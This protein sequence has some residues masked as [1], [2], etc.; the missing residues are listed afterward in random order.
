MIG[1][2]MHQSRM[3]WMQILLWDFLI[4]ISILA[5]VAW[6]LDDRYARP[7]LQYLVDFPYLGKLIY[8]SP[9]FGWYAQWHYTVFLAP[10]LLI[11]I[12]VSFR[13]ARIPG[14]G[15]A[16]F[17]WW[18]SLLQLRVRKEKFEDIFPPQ[19]DRK[20]PEVAQLLADLASR[21]PLSRVVGYYKR[22][23]SD[24]E[25]DRRAGRQPEKPGEYFPIVISESMRYRHIQVLG[26]T[27]SGKSA[28]IIAPMLI[29]D[30]STARI[31]TVTINPKADLYLLKV[32]AHGVMKRKRANPADRM[33]TAVISFSRTDS[34]AYDPLLYGDADTLTKKIIG[35][36][37]ISHPFYRSFQET[38]LMSF[39]RVIKT[40]PLLVDRIMLRHLFRFLTRPKEVEEALMSLCASEHNIQRLRVLATA[41]PEFLAGVASHL[42]LLVEDESLA[43]IFDNPTGPQLN[44]REVIRRGGNIFLDLDL[45]TKGPQ[46]RALGRMIMME[47]QLLAGSRQAGFESKTTG[48]QVYLD[49]FASF[50]YNGFIDLIDKCRSARVGLL[51][52]HQSLGNLQRDNLTKS[53]KDEVVDN[54][55]CKFFL[56]LKDQTAEWASRQMGTR[57][58]LKKT[59]TIGHATEQTDTRGRQ[60]H[61]LA[62]REE[63]EPYVQ[64]SDLHVE[65]GHGY[66]NVVG[67]D[68]RMIRCPI[69]VGYIDEND[70]CSDQE[71]FA[72]LRTTLAGHPSRPR[73]GSLI[74]NA[75]PPGMPSMPVSEAVPISSLDFHPAGRE[76]T[77][78]DLEAP[79]SQDKGPAGP[80]PQNDLDDLMNGPTDKEE[81]ENA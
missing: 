41:K 54:S 77:E 71:L 27:G 14:P 81:D 48:V 3:T 64:P 15:R 20:S 37:E 66:G 7:A 65:M 6:Y 75:I 35:S 45:N 47:I 21:E 33:P 30:A 70:L 68:G 26:G 58:I 5:A 46:G 38:W 11:S 60:S 4:P 23:P 42:S 52:A 49:E 62:F 51:L 10:L 36:S 44:I 16:F 79:D 2:E 34:L 8:R 59:L 73:G 69:R 72:F 32:L 50:A 17:R 56:T 24:I 74:D 9:V 25:L 18:Q 80:V 61:T 13:T 28:S 39:F 40:E 1:H 63:F 55:F 31:A 43:H 67:R 22:F 19:F 57:K 53:F 29:D 78:P 76:E 12:S